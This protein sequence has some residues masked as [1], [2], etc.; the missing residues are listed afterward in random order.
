[1]NYVLLYTNDSIARGFPLKW[2]SAINHATT[3]THA[4]PRIKDWR[5][6]SSI[7]KIETKK[8][9]NEGW[10]EL[11]YDRARMTSCAR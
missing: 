11:A 6:S 5:P 3:P 8:E 10:G 7:Q 9:G 4:V 2:A 1:M